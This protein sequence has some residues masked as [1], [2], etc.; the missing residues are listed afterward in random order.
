MKRGAFIGSLVAAGLVL[1]FNGPADAQ[2][3]GQKVIVVSLS[4]T[5]DPLSARYVERGIRTGASERAAAVLIRIDTPGGLDS[6]MRSIITAISTSSV[7]VVCWVGPSGARAASAGAIILTGCPIAAMAPGPNVGAAHPV[8]FSG[9]VLDEKITN[10][11]AAYAR[12]LAQ[13][14]NR[15]ADLAERM[16]RES[17]SVPAEEALRQRAIDLIA[18]TQR[19]V[20]AD[21]NGRT[22]NGVTLAVSSPEFVTTDM[23]FIEALLHGAVDPNIAF[24]LF[25]L[26]LVGIVFEILHPGITLPGV[27]GSLAF[28]VSLVLLGLLPVNIAGVV[29]LLVGVVFFAFE[30]HIHSFGVAAALGIASLI[31]GGLFLFNSAVP[32]AQVSKWLVVGMAIALAAFFTLVVRAV[33]RARRQLPSP[34]KLADFVGM[35]GVVVR[36]L[37]PTGIV[38]A[39]REQWSATSTGP[40]IPEGTHVRIVG[41]QGLTL[42]VEPLEVQASEPKGGKG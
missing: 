26:G 4:G 17:V 38:R 37:D 10:D 23:T 41:V 5:V 33:V 40:A 28:L 3:T 2:T 11:A 8:G 36:A 1:S 29:L 25:L 27:L 31:L 24:I 12:A 6:S 19:A 35:E 34:H 30:V 7:P 20:F 42:E 13:S 15:N 16:V 21:L 18:P 32:N 9:D 39:R 22:V 14:H